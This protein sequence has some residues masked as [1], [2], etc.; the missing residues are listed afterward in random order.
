MT[1]ILPMGLHFH[2]LSDVTQ[3]D[4]Q[5]STD[6][7]QYLKT[8]VLVSGHIAKSRFA[9]ISAAAKLFLGDASLFKDYPKL[10]V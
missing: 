1:T 10:L 5:R 4:M 2:K 8:D 3:V 6:P 7:R 9:N